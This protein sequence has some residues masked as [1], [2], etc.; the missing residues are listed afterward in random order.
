MKKITLI[1]IAVLMGL[2]LNAQ[3]SVWDGTAERWTHG[4]GTEDD[5]Y[6][7]ENAQQ[8]AYI[9]EKTNENVYNGVNHRTMYVDTCFLLTVD[10]DFGASSGLEWEP[11]GT[12]GNLS[13]KGKFGGHFDGGGH[14]ISNINFSYQNT[15]NFFGI[16]GMM[17]GG[18][19]RNILVDD[20]EIHIS[21][22]YAYTYGQSGLILGYGS[23][24]IVENCI[25]KADVVW[26]HI[27][28]DTNGCVLGGLFGQ[29]RN[30]I[31]SNCHNYGNIR[32]PNV[33]LMHDGAYIGGLCGVIYESD[34][35]NCSNLG[36]IYVQGGDVYWGGIAICGGIASV[37]SG[38]M[39]YCFNNGDCDV[40]IVV[41]ET[42]NN[43]KSAGGLIGGVFTSTLAI[44]NS[45]SAS[46]IIMSGNNL[47]T[48]Y[49]GIVGFVAD[50]VQVEVTDSYYLDNIA[51]NNYGIPQSE[52]FMKTQDFVNLLNANGD[53]Y[54]MDIMNVN[55]GYPV[56]ERYYSV[57]E[58][59]FANGISVY[60]NPAKDVVNITFSNNAKCRSIDIYSI[61]GRLMKSQ[62]DS[63]NKINIANLTSGLYLIKVRMNDGKEFTEKIVVK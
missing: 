56:F 25:N 51:N 12:A 20:A 31:V 50:T 59:D 61:D 46:N 5:P 7:I 8:L 22:A 49:G 63:F 39:E 6:L 40:N 54:A 45:Y 30:S 32:L 23:N 1:I 3:I 47:P 38:S 62:N 41:E 15:S 2:A 35:D 13:W 60:P 52:A 58:T 36:D 21:E 10:I 18:S 9:A 14:S 26:D 19:L 34:I 37:M 44:S 55:K 28:M 48:Y 11:I 42:N 29:L 4:S 43:V 33:E 24:V 16:F 57:E 27:S 17:E 53:F